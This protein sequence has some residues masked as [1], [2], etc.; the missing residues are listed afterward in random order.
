M[1]KTAII[2]FTTC[3]LV[4][5][6][7]SRQ[8]DFFDSET[9]PGTIIIKEDTLMVEYSEYGKQHFL[10]LDS[11]HLTHRLGEEVE[12]IY[13]LSAPENATINKL[14][15]YWIV[16]AEIS[17]AFGIFAV[18]LGIA[19]ATTHRPHASSVKEQLES[20]EEKKTKYD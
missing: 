1:I 9:A 4:Y 10:R 14:I 7:F 2:L 8:P 19:Y 11:S 17:W 20:K 13:E 6:P 15:G 12:V 5:L 16:P 3:F 18:L